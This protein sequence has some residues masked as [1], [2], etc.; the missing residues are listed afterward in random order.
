MRIAIPL[1]Q[2]RV[3]PVFDVASR[4]LLVDVSDNQE[5]HRQEE[6]LT[7]QNPFERAHLLPKLGVDLLI[8]GMISQTQQTALASAGIQ[9]IPCIC[10]AM[11][12]VIAAFL[13][14]RLEKGGLLMP[15]CR[16][17]KSMR[18]CPARLS[19]QEGSKR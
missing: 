10:G 13:E 16:G 1:W 18:N 5:Q 17:R 3:S 4:V 7:T 15:G 8:C 14:G 19:R 9:I 2:G 12:E 6:F 11:D